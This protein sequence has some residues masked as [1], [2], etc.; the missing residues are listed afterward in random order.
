MT[1]RTMKRA[2][3]WLTG[4]L[5]ATGCG[6]QATPD[7]PGE[8][9]SVIQGLVLNEGDDTPDDAVVVVSW[10]IGMFGFGESVAEVEG[11][12]PAQFSLALY[13]PPPEHVL[14]NP[15]EPWVFPEGHPFDPADEATIA[16]G[17]IVAVAKDANGDPDPS[18]VLGGAEGHLVLYAE[19]DIEEGSLTAEMI[20]ASAPAGYHLVEVLPQDPEAEEDVVTCQ[21]AA[22]DLD[23]WHECGF[24]QGWAL[25]ANDSEVAVRLV[26]SSEL[27]LPYFSPILL[28][29]NTDLDPAPGCMMGDPMCP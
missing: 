19:T 2:C 12:F 8:K 3:G 1:T 21:A 4:A 26:D 28:G 18:A 13:E 20:G 16:I 27:S 10:G 7:Y 14:H 17:Q 15:A 23:E 22:T 6:S 5:I 29:P 25:A 24:V 11:E 9:L